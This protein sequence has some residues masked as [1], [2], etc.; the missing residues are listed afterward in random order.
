MQV[1][2][3]CAPPLYTDTALRRA[4][5]GV[6]RALRLTVLAL[7]GA[8]LVACRTAGAAA[9]ALPDGSYAGSN[10]AAQAVTVDIV[11]GAVSDYDAWPTVRQAHGGFRSPHFQVD[12]SCRSAYHNT[13]LF[14][15]LTHGRSTQ[16]VEL[17]KL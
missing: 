1:T 17:M 5:S 4:G 15:R 2:N 10:A 11:G 16:T 14:C 6:G 9:A 12:L 8:S 7:I 13:E 3:L